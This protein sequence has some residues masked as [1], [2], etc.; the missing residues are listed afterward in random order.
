MPANPSFLIFCSVNLVCHSCRYPAIEKPFDNPHSLKGKPVMPRH[1]CHVAFVE[2]K[3]HP[4]RPLE[5]TSSSSRKSRE[6]TAGPGIYSEVMT[7]EDANVLPLF[8]LTFTKAGARS[9]AAEKKKKKKNKAKPMEEAE[10]AAESKAAGSEVKAEASPVLVPT[11]FSGKGREGDFAWMIKQDKY[12]RHFFIYND[13]EEAMLSNSTRPGGGNSVIRPYRAS[14]TPRSWGIPTGSDGEGYAMLHEAAKQHINTA[15]NKIVQLCTEHACT[16]V[17]Y[18][19]KSES[20]DSLGTA[21]FSPAPS[22]CK[23]ILESLQ[24]HFRTRII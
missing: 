24:R 1:D 11:V 9:G 18:S 4:C 19:A 14:F 13:N 12:K 8:S 7:G 3:G 2:E 10:A 20:D 23:Y 5:D 21:I 15:V 22:V 17:H 16:H 6:F